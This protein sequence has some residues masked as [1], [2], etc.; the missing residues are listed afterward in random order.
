MLAA[1]VCHSCYSYHLCVKM[2]P[3]S[4]QVQ[5]ARRWPCPETISCRQSKPTVG[6]SGSQQ[7]WFHSKE[8]KKKKSPQTDNC[9]HDENIIVLFDFFSPMFKYVDSQIQET[10]SI[11]N[12]FKTSSSPSCCET[13]GLNP[14]E[15]LNG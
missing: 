4:H 13:I 14:P 1:F 7:D 9:F 3:N 10:Q 11:E 15:I 12:T 6:F 5:T 8:K 2:N